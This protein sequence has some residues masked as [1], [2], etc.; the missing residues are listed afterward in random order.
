MLRY[1]PYHIPK[2]IP[3]SRRPPAVKQKR[4]KKKI[5]QT[6]AQKRNNGDENV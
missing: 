3:R 6:K 1:L 5:R 4:K 2:F